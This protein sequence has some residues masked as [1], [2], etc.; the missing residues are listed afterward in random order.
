MCG[1]YGKLYYP[2]PRDKRSMNAWKKAARILLLPV[3]IF[4]WLVGWS[5]FWIGIR[6]KSR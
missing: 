5:F 3:I 2:L 1:D 6:G 4:V